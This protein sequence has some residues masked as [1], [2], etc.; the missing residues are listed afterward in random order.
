VRRLR[1]KSDFALDYGQRRAAA[2]YSMAERNYPLSF[3]IHQ[4]ALKL[5]NAH[6]IQDLLDSRACL[7]QTP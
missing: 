6:L 1:P 2:I 3:D 7:I 5:P 4:L